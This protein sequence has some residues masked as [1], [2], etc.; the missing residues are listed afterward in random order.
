MR[1]KP[2]KPLETESEKC[3]HVGKSEN[4]NANSRIG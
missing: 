3:N 2:L 1:N 4:E